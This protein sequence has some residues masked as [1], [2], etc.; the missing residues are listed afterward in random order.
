MRS[1]SI[2]QFGPSDLRGR[3][4]L[5]LEIV[6]VTIG[7]RLLDGASFKL[8]MSAGLVKA[9]DLSPFVIVMLS[10][11]SLVVTIA[12]TYFSQKLRGLNFTDYGLE[13]NRL[14]KGATFWWLIFG[15][16]LLQAIDRYVIERI[17]V[18]FLHNP[19]NIPRSKESQA[20]LNLLLLVSSEAVF[21]RNY[22]FGAI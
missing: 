6:L 19:P 12:I 5:A 15:S 10:T 8:L 14:P 18:L 13:L 1:G 21:G 22:F 3:L 16:M 17:A 4:I 9:G 11:I 2:R 20:S 7:L